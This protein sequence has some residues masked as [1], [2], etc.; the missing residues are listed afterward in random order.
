LSIFVVVE[1][2]IGAIEFGCGGGEKSK[3]WRS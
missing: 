3:M 2:T 1:V